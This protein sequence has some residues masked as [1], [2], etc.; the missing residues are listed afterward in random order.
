MRTRN[1]SASLAVALAAALAV[2]ACGGGS[3]SSNGRSASTKSKG[4]TEVDAATDGSLG[5]ILTTA[6]GQVLYMFP[7]DDGRRVSCVGACAVMWPPLTA[8][9]HQPPAAGQG[10]QQSLLG[11]DPNPAGGP[12][13]VTYSGWPLYT[14][15]DD[16]K[17]GQARGQSFLS[18][19]GYWYVIAPD[20]VPNTAP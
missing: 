5:T 9:A 18:Y 1:L 13:V 11:T 2:T 3:P 8:K 7:P 6:S 19:G 15:L 14:Y 16:A 20:G 4:A 10:V 17:P 12:P